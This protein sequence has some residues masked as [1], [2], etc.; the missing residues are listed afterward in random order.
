ME[1]GF[2]SLKLEK[3]CSYMAKDH[4]AFR[5][6]AEKTGMTLEKTYNKPNNRKFPTI[7]YSKLNP[8]PHS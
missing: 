1:Y 3:L 7:V 2:N 5:K 6:V 8:E 4:S